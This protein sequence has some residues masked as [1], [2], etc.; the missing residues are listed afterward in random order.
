MYIVSSRD[1]T[2]LHIRNLE[3]DKRSVVEAGICAE[4]SPE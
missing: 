2:E 3:M 1:N 4:S